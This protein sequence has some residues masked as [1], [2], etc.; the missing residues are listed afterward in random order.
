MELAIV[1]AYWIGLGLCAFG[2]CM[3][4]IMLANV[5]SAGR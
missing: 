1:T 2:F 5:A 3:G 4:L